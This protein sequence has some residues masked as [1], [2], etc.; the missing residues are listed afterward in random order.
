[1]KKTI[2]LGAIA[3]AGVTMLIPFAAFAQD[4]NGSVGTNVDAVIQAP[5]PGA[6]PSSV[7]V[8][9][10]A[11]ANASS[12]DRA[13]MRAQRLAAMQAHDGTR[14]QTA[15]TEIN[16]RIASLNK[17]SARVSGAKHLSAD[18]KS[19]INGELS[20]T[21]SDMTSLEAKIGTDTGSTTAADKA[22]ITKDYRVYALVLPQAAIVAA[23]DR[24]LD[25]VTQMQTLGTKLEARITAN[26]AKGIDTTAQE[27]AYADFTAKVSA[28][29]TSAQSSA[30]AVA[31]LTPD[32][33]DKT[34]L[35]SNTAALK[36]GR[37]D[38]KSAEASLKAAR[39]DID[40]ILKANHITASASASTTVTAQ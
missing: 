17:L 36:T 35:A 8:S 11:G 4:V 3:A 14:V 30:S 25:V 7:T 2:T 1:M 37:D 19:T 38:A 29:Q 9:G 6:I 33:G 15:D 31:G 5:V 39:A 21:L 22:T 27:A 26:K 40:V 20:T 16:A 10:S 24:E 34:I 32:N 18:Q 23:S 12:S 13:A 28:A